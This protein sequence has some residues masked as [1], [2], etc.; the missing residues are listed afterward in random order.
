MNPIG[1]F[2]WD[3]ANVD[4]ILRHALTPFEVEEAARRP[5][6]TISA[7]TVDSAKGAARTSRPS[8]ELL[9]PHSVLREFLNSEKRWKLFGKTA[10]SRYLVGVYNSPEAVPRRDRLRNECN[11]EEDVCPA[12]P[13]MSPLLSPMQRKP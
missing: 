2:D 9:A 13:L 7:K 1:G 4:R 5:H 12:N 3:A 10:S 8:E 6:V 11:G